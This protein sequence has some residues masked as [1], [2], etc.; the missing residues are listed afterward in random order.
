MIGAPLAETFAA[1]PLPPAP[2]LPSL[3]AAP[4]L[5]LEPPPIECASTPL[6]LLPL[7]RSVPPAVSWISPP[8][9]AEP[10][11]APSATRPLEPPAEPP[12]PPAP[13]SELAITPNRPRLAFDGRAQFQAR[14]T[15]ALLVTLTELA[16]PP[17]APATP[18]PAAPPPETPTTRRAPFVTAAE[19]V[20]KVTGA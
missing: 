18:W 2:P 12:P 17:C 19:P 9:P 8:L 7:V 3:P 13:P 11:S 15:G 20:V 14:L 4:A 10:P 6:A 16:L 1:P 5:P